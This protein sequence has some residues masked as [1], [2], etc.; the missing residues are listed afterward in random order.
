MSKTPKLVDY[1]IFNLNTQGP[2]PTIY[3]KTE[4]LSIFLNGIILI[5]IVMGF[6]FLYYRY[7]TKEAYDNNINKQLDDLNNLIYN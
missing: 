7:I 1:S 4:R 5:S 6:G 3:T 2:R